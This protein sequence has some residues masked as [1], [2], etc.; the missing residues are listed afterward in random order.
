[1]ERA[2]KRLRAEETPDRTAIDAVMER[3]GTESSQE[4]LMIRRNAITETGFAQPPPQ[5]EIND[6][7]IQELGRSV[8]PAL[9]KRECI[10]VV[11]AAIQQL[12]RIPGNS[13]ATIL[14]GINGYYVIRDGTSGK[15]C[16]KVRYAAVMFDGNAVTRIHV[17]L[18]D[19]IP[20]SEASYAKMTNQPCATYVG[21]VPIPAS[22]T[23]TRVTYAFDRCIKDEPSLV[24]GT[25][26]RNS[27][28]V[29]DFENRS[30]NEVY[31]KLTALS[32]NVN[33]AGFGVLF[34]WMVKG[35]SSEANSNAGNNEGPSRLVAVRM[36]E[37]VDA[38]YRNYQKGSEATDAEVVS[39]EY[40]IFVNVTT[41]QRQG[42]GSAIIELSNTGYAGLYP[43]TSPVS[44]LIS[45]LQRSS[46]LTS[47]N[48]RPVAPRNTRPDLPDFL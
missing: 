9:L 45:D 14:T 15:N 17:R 36:S 35:V 37:S 24:A 12:K 1:M 22:Q 41:R 38:T 46:F 13:P 33:A 19:R 5:L 3:I 39:N 28:V 16:L 26:R 18:A 34:V 30:I 2:N 11:E 40:M 44:C 7:F 25:N 8:M 10:L 31:T 43:C 21:F 47:M 29:L 23:P 32:G 20:E 42:T 48:R 4:E 6:M 27:I